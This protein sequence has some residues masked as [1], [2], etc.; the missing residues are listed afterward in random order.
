MDWMFPR[1]VLTSDQG[2]DSKMI[3]FFNASSCEPALTFGPNSFTVS[4]SEG[5]PD[6]LLMI[7]SYPA[8]AACLTKAFAILPAPIVPIFILLFF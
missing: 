2:M 1:T 4:A 7:T 8:A 6:L 5:G 3:S